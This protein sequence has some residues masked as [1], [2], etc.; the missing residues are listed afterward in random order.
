MK[1]ILITG[2]SQGIG[3]ATANFFLE[4]GYLVLGTSTTGKIEIKSDHFIPLKLDLANE[5]SQKKLINKIKHFHIDVLV[6]N[7]S[8]LLEEWNESSIKLD[9]LKKTFDVN[10]FGII[11]FTERIIPQLTQ[12]AHI[13]NISSGWG[14][15]S[16]K[17]LNEFVPCYKMSKAAIN[18]YT[19]L[20]SKRLHNNKVVALDPGWVKTKMG[21]EK[22]NKYPGQVAEEIFSIV[23][24]SIES[25]IFLL[26]NTRRQ[27]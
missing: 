2:T 4:K 24:G 18:F 16:D 9:T 15:F 19:I 10:F 12:D 25:G 14:T 11:S 3:K 20:L 7:A 5:S 13:I 22:A 1:S 26:N 17:N 6:N 27:W 23:N 21:S 8:I